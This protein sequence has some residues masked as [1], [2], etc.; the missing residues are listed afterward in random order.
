MRIGP[1]LQ[2]IATHNEIEKSDELKHMRDAPFTE[3]GLN[4]IW[5]T[6][7]EIT[8]FLNNLLLNPIKQ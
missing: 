4:P 5:K 2:E 7:V 3:I 6:D 8:S 1:S